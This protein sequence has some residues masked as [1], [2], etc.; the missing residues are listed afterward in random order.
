MEVTKNK[1]QAPQGQEGK[2]PEIDPAIIEELMKGYQRPEDL[3]G[4]GGIIEHTRARIG[5]HKTFRVDRYP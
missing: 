1:E 2:K 5:K 4:P 3:T